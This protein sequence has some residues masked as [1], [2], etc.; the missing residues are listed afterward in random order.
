MTGPTHTE[1]ASVSD[2][3]VAAGLA[4]AVGDDQACAHLRVAIAYHRHSADAD[5]SSA[6]QQGT[7]ALAEVLVAFEEARRIHAERD[8]QATSR[9][10]R[11]ENV[12][13]ELVHRGPCSTA[14]LAAALHDND[15]R[16]RAALRRLARDGLVQPAAARNGRARRYELSRAG[17]A[18]A[19]AG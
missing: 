19:M 6:M 11:R 14:E 7:A 18:A 8:R 2:L 4:M 17:V 1:L 15:G 3:S 10:P 5:G 16:V 12:L 13:M 9:H